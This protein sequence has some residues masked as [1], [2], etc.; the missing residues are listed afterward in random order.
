MDHLF[1]L[2]LVGLVRKVV[3]ELQNHLGVVD[4]NLAEFIIAQR[5]DSDT[6][7]MFER[8][9]TRAGGDSLPPSLL[10]SIDRLVRMMHPSMKAKTA[11]IVENTRVFSGLA[12]PDNAPA[13]DS[14]DDAFNE[15]EALEL[16]ACN[17]KSQ[18]QKRGRSRSQ[19]RSPPTRGKRRSRSGVSH[20][21]RPR[22]RSYDGGIHRVPVADR[23]QCNRQGREGDDHQEDERIS[24]RPPTEVD[25][26]PILYGIYDGNVTGIKNFGVFVNIHG[27]SGN[28]RGLVHISRLADGRNH[29]ADS[30][31]HGHP[32]RSRSSA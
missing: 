2:E 4:K 28:L 6:F 27:V 30:V 11:T 32:S 10:E 13:S 5:L 7:E 22:C 1:D 12:L 3:S 25:E 8:N 21:D 16:K 18:M 9:M 17:N 23:Q 31:E 20:R 15:L 24:R 26:S 29:P 14:V 19:S